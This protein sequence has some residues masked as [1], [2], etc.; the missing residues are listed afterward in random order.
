[1]FL[2]GGIAL[3]IILGGIFYWYQYAMEQRAM[4]QTENIQN[5]NQELLGLEQ[6]LNTAGL[7]DLDT[8]LN[9]IEQEIVQ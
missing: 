7:N 1:M 8:E 4:P 6:E 5:T 3:I 2:I 9:D